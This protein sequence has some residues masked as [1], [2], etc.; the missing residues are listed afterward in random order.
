[1]NTS[2]RGFLGGLLASIVAAPEI[3]E[4]IV[5]GRSFISLYS[6]KILIPSQTETLSLELERISRKI[7]AFFERQD[8]FFKSI[9]KYSDSI[10]VGGIDMRIPLTI[11]PSGKFKL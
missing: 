2:R 6:P 9:E 5:K 10:W 3:I 8:I 1:M 11:E 7:P 4:E